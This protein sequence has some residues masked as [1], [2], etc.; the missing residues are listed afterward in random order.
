MI[1]KNHKSTSRD[2][3][4]AYEASADDLLAE[5]EDRILCG[6]KPSVD[7]YIDRYNGPEPHILRIELQLAK[8]LL[9]AGRQRRIAT[10]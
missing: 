4:S 2:I 5:Y 9:L 3:N 1:H 7:E 6:E 10:N 8:A